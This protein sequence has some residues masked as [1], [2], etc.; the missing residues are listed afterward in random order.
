MSHIPYGLEVS[1]SGTNRMPSG[2]W[3][4]TS[5]ASL[6]FETFLMTYNSPEVPSTEFSTLCQ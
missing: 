3:H 1:W 5:L 4:E 6:H 2:K